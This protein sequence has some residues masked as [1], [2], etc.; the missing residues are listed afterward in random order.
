LGFKI[1]NKTCY[2][3]WPY[4]LDIIEKT[5]DIAL[6]VD[7]DKARC[8]KCERYEHYDYQYPSKSRHL[9]IVHS[10]DVY[11]SKVVEDVH[12]SSKTTSIIEDISIDSDTPIL[13]EGYA[14]YEGTSELA[15]VIV[16]SIHH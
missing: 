13:G 12:I 14:S 6:K 3:H 7:Y 1:Q 11:D 2:D 10:N 4:D 5:F 9:S 16:E 15:N 8:S